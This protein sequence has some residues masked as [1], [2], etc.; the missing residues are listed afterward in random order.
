[1][2]YIIQE[3]RAISNYGI[4]HIRPMDLVFLHPE[5]SSVLKHIPDTNQTPQDTARTPTVL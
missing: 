2:Q 4:F 5:T 3:E 1:M